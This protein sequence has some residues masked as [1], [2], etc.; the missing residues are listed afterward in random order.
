[1]IQNRRPSLSAS[2]TKSIDQRWLGP[3]AGSSGTRVTAA[4]LRPI[5]A[6]EPA[7]VPPR[8]ADV[9]SCGSGA[10]PRATAVPSDVASRS[11]AG[12]PPIRATGLDRSVVRT[13][14]AIADRRPIAPDHAARPPLA[15]PMPIAH[16]HHGLTPGSGRHHFLKRCP[17]AWHCP[18]SSPPA[19]SSAD[20]S[21]P[22]AIEA[23]WPPTR[24][25]R[26]TSPS[27]CRTSR[28]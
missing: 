1:M 11:G 18:A 7:A 5:R 22:P 21:R 2:C 15:H 24:R 17:S 23:A 4:R 3:S 14:A 26:H 12:L 27:T 16:V 28:C 6:G 19:A 25:D 8:T 13:P 10:R 9:A 20:G